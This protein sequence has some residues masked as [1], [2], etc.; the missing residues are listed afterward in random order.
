M[1]W[2]VE[3]RECDEETVAAVWTRLFPLEINFAN[4]N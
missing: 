2:N 3:G 1:K 4:R